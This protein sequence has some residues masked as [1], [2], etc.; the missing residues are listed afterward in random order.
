MTPKARHIEDLLEPE[1]NELES[2]V[3]S[4]GQL[5]ASVK[6]NSTRASS[7]RLIFL[8][9]VSTIHDERLPGDVRSLW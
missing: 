4:S 1:A 5:P 9:E 6:E 7:R 2:R 3:C 8:Q